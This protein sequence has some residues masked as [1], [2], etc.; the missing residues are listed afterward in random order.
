M[1]SFEEYQEIGRRNKKLIEE[2]NENEKE[3]RRRELERQGIPINYINQENSNFHGDCDSIGS[4]E[5][6]Q[7]TMLYIV[8]MLVGAIFVDR[9]IIWVIATFIWLKFIT[10]NKK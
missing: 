10:R 7:A 5:N 6:W 4:L 9:L 1:L 3:L 8:A 2:W